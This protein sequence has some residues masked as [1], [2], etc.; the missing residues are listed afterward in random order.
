M[1]K[2]A[3]LGLGVMGSPMAG[4]I[5]EKGHTVSVY[6]RSPDKAEA[7]ANCYKGT[8]ASTPAEAATGCDVVVSCVGNDDSVRD[9]TSG[10]NGAFS[11]MTPGSIFVDHTTTSA[12]LARELSEV[13]EKKGLIFIDAPVSG[14]QVGAENGVLTVM[15]GGDQAA[16]EKAKSVIECY[17]RAVT[18]MGKSGS[19]QLTKM[20]NQVCTAGLVQALSEGLAFSEKV[21]LDAQR[22]LDV[23]SKGAAQSWQMDNRGSTM[24]EGKF[25]F[26]FAVDHMRKDLGICLDEARRNA[27]SLPITAVVDQLYS[28]VQANGGNRWDTSSL[29]T[30]LNKA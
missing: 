23:I 25:E 1:A 29:I 4:H 20:V 22:V 30:L 10:E 19:G 2:V 17:A 15:A 8:T 28:Q 27:A 16:Y 24:V 14:G 26:G 12:E 13:S 11:T 18:Y 7:W 5:A 21:G 3:F 6:N 9:I